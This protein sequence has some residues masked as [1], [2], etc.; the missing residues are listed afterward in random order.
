MA[1][2]K[3]VVTT[4]RVSFSAREVPPE[5]HVK[6]S[7]KT[8]SVQQPFLFEHEHQATRRRPDRDLSN[9]SGRALEFEELS[10]CIASTKPQAR[11]PRQTEIPWVC[12]PN[13]GTTARP[14]R[15]GQ[16]MVDVKMHEKNHPQRPGISFSK[17]SAK[18]KAQE[19]VGT[20]SA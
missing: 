8:T 2:A 19:K 5:V 9:I 12:P 4:V 16:I 6:V 10:A 15:G 3:N 14:G 1:Q 7:R 17:E 13:F 18:K 11:M 20:A